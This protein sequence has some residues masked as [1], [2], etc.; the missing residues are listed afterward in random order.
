VVIEGAAAHWPQNFIPA[1]FSKLQ[2]EQRIPLPQGACSAA[3]LRDWPPTATLLRSDRRV[4]KILRG[5]LKVKRLETKKPADFRISDDAAF[6]T[7]ESLAR[8]WA[9]YVYW[10]MHAALFSLSNEASRRARK[11]FLPGRR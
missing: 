9:R 5:G 7:L 4:P 2:I 6:Q 10:S 11:A 1:G 3:V 8:G